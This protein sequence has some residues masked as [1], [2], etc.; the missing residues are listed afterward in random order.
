MLIISLVFLPDFFQG[1]SGRG[2]WHGPQWLKRSVIYIWSIE[3]AKDGNLNEI[4]CG[5]AQRE[6]K[7]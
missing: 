5:E 3:L 4:Y 1:V 6:A 7:M 2:W